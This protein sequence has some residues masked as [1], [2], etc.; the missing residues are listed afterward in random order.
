MF[1][2]VVA[3]ESISVQIGARLPVWASISTIGWWRRL[4]RPMW[5]I[6]AAPVARTSSTLSRPGTRSTTG[7]PGLNPSLRL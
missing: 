2:G 6:G 5:S 4:K 1:W 3:L 7:C